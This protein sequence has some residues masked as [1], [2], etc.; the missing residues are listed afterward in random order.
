MEGPYVLCS[1]KGG[2]DGPDSREV[3]IERSARLH[4]SPWT[5]SAGGP[6]SPAATRRVVVA[7]SQAASEGMEEQ[8]EEVDALKLELQTPVPR[9]LPQPKASTRSNPMERG[10]QLSSRASP[11]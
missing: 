5:G 10:A 4:L 2:I 8:L 6:D 1:P 7:Q 3:V 11:A 9:P